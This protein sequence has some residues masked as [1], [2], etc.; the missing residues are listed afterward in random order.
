VVGL[1]L[2]LKRRGRADTD[3]AEDRAL[4]GQEFRLELL[5]EDALGE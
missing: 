4:V 2:G 3:V 1:R 5:E